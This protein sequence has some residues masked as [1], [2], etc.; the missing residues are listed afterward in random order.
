MDAIF[1]GGSPCVAIFIHEIGQEDE[2][3]QNGGAQREDRLKMKKLAS[4]HALVSVTS[5]T[6]THPGTG[7]ES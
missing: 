5:P 6:Q 3:P 1:R 4:A 7:H 2:R